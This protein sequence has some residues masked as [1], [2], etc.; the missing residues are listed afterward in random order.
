MSCQSLKKEL[1]SSLFPIKQTTL[2]N[3]LLYRCIVLSVAETAVWRILASAH[4]Q[5]I[6]DTAWLI[7]T[8]SDSV[9]THTV[10]LMNFR[11]DLSFLPAHFRLSANLLSHNVIPLSLAPVVPQDMAPLRATSLPAE[12]YIPHHADLLR[13]CRSREMMMMS[14]ITMGSS[15]WKR[16]T[17]SLNVITRGGWFNSFGLWFYCHAD[18]VRL[19]HLSVWC[20]ICLKRSQL[21]RQDESH[22]NWCISLWKEKPDPSKETLLSSVVYF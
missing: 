14:P 10:E 16:L 3:H 11:M 5:P 15:K 21:G 4:H 17:N 6:S 13:T 7:P 2:I 20:Q 1:F 22:Y 8:L 12:I 19:S 9:C 18:P